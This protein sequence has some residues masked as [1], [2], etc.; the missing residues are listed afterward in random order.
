MNKFNQSIKNI[1][2]KF[3]YEFFVIQQ[4]FEVRCTCHDFSTKQGE[5]SCKKCL[6]TGYKI[7]IKKIKGAS[8]DRKI[9]YRNLALEERSVAYTYF[10]DEKYPIYE[11]NIIVDGELALVAYRV[12]RSKTTEAVY[13]KCLAVQK[14]SDSNLLLRMF[15]DIVK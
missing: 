10:I 14:K 11:D 1:I 9:T 13:S 7:K 3:E 12:E 4:N 2:K 8:E 5:P 15:K 6:G